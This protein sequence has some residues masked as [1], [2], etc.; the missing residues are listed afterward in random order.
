MVI[1]YGILP[2]ASAAGNC[3][4]T[5][6]RLFPPCRNSISTAGARG[7]GGVRINGEKQA[8]H[9]VGPLLDGLIHGGRHAAALELERVVGIESLRVGRVGAHRDERRN[10]HA[11]S[12]G[13]HDKFGA[14]HPDLAA[15][16]DP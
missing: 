13:R 16:T 2:C 15:L 3:I 1:R 4:G 14:L 5:F 8:Q 11:G 7:N 12:F 10:P 6:V 9:R